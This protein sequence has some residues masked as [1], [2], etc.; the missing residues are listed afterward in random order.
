MPVSALQRKLHAAAVNAPKPTPDPFIGEP[1]IHFGAHLWPVRGNWEW[2]AEKWNELAAIITGRC[3]VVVVLD[4]NTDTLETVRSK[5]SD[6]FEIVTAANTPDGENPSFRHLQTIM[7]TGPDDVLLYCHGKG[8]RGHTAK[9]ESVRIWTEIMYETVVFNHS[10]VIRKLS[11]GY[12]IFGSFRTFGNMPLSP[13]NQWHYSGTFFAVRAK[14]IAGKPVKNGY[15]GVEAWPGDTFMSAESWCE[16]SDCPGFKFGY[17]LNAVYPAIVDAQMQWE[18]NRIG[19][20]RCEQHQRELDWFGAQTESGDV[21]LVLGSK[22]GGLERVL[23]DDWLCCTVSVDIAP[24]SDNRS[25]NLIT[26]S[27]HDEY[28]REQIRQAGPF[29]VVFIDGDHS[30]AGV[31]ADW[32]FALTLKP[33]L[34]AFHDI[35]TAVKHS[36]E[37]CEVDKLWKQIKLSY[38]TTE[39]CV[40]AGWGGIG[41]VHL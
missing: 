12:K 27:S 40:G 20:P 3:V 18:V 28:V 8:V 36:R 17:D 11:E 32:E 22:H 35:A 14:H 33:R 39:K 2:H 37:G 15:G 30:Y 10:K 13:R 21:V 25:P 24:Q 5:L 19:G 38:A 4:R 16:F 6:R 1:V 23:N 41:V 7:P 29:D 26:G 9:S 31:Q 34:I